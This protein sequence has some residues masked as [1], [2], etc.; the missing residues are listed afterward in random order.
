MDY[1]ERNE[2][3]WEHVMD[4]CLA[5]PIHLQD[6]A[7]VLDRWVAKGKHA[8]ESRHSSGD[9]GMEIHH[10]EDRTL[11]AFGAGAPDDSQMT[12]EAYDYTASLAFMERDEALLHSLFE[13]FLETWSH[14]VV[15]MEEA[16]A[17]EDRESLQRHAHQLKGALY[18]LNA[19]RQAT[20]AEKLEAE[21]EGAPFSQL[22]P[23]FGI[24]KHQVE[25]LVA[26][27]KDVLVVKSGKKGPTSQE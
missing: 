1:V 20:V 27:F 3:Q 10:T 8:H 14:L 5:K 2:S 18:A 13:I 19:N 6:L 15:G 11:T 25:G 24:M 23:M 16:I 9:G 26:L 7:N 4:D 12:Y 21:A 17:M 22:Q